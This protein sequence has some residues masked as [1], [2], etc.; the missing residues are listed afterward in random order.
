M[1]IDRIIY[2][3]Y[4]LGPGKRIVIWFAGCSKKCRNCA[5][6]ELWHKENKQKISINSVKRILEKTI[7]ENEVDGVTLTGGDPL[8]QDIKQIIELVE[9]IK[10][11]K[12]I[13]ILLYT[14]Y[15]RK[16]IKKDKN[17]EKVLN[18]IDVLID[19][20]YIEGLND[21]SVILRGS[22]NQKIYY[23]S[24]QKKE[25]YI[26]YMKEYGRKVQNIYC[27]GK[28]ISVGIHNKLN[29]KEM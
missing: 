23:L 28:L 7:K 27:N 16:E 18:K 21:N 2:P 10:E 26:N 5:N 11:L 6:P 20:R 25:I 14:G 29:Y 22:S 13:D 8:E 9:F 17:L 24:E 19:G 3:I 12:N 1:Y 4:T 15:L